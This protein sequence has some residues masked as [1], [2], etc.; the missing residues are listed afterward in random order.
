MKKFILILPI[1]ALLVVPCLSN[2]DVFDIDPDKPAPGITDVS[3][4]GST[5]QMISNI[6]F[7]LLIA[8]TVIFV[9]WAAYLFLTSAGDEEKTKKARNVIVYAIVAIVVALLAKGLGTM[10]IEFLGKAD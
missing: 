3:D 5:L 6:M 10:V 4:F 8:L 2:A 7:W 1:V 9:L